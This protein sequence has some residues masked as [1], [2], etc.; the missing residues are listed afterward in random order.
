VSSLIAVA[1][2][3]LLQ[4]AL[5]GVLDAVQ[6]VSKVSF[7]ATN[8]TEEEHQVLFKS[9][10][11]LNLNLTKSSKSVRGLGVRTK[12]YEIELELMAMTPGNAAAKEVCEQQLRD[13]QEQH[14]SF[15][16]MSPTTHQ[17]KTTTHQTKKLA[18]DN[19]VSWSEVFSGIRACADR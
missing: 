15:D 1:N 13:Y 14:L 4:A 2:I 19:K 3:A 10:V 8:A 6:A 11:F 9:E 12:T 7:G 5:S 18:V 17:T 16:P